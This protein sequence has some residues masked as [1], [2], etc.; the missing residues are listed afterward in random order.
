MNVWCY[1]FLCRHNLVK[2]IVTPL[3]QPIKADIAE[4]TLKFLREVINL[5]K[6]YNINDNIQDYSLIIN[7]DKTPLYFNMPLSNTIINR[8]TKDIIINTLGKE[9]SKFQ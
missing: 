3:G 2:R 5:R 4:F 6:L 1:L 8:G 7:V 9:K